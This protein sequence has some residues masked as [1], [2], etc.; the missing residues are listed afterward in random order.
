MKCA[1]A[2]LFATILAT[3]PIWT[4]AGSPAFA[5]DDPKQNRRHGNPIA[6]LQQQID[7][8]SAR[9]A[10]LEG[11]GSVPTA[12]E[13]DYAFTATETCS[14]T[15]TGY[16]GDFN[17]TDALSIRHFA[18]DGVL[19]YRANGTGTPRFAPAW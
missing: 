4:S 7:A 13:G 10:T 6:G 2:R 12:L 15:R 3:A 17:A 1:K 19:S 18:S 14:T 8:L 9:M 11:T 16:D 5:H